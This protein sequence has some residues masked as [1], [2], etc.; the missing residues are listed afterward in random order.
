M[1]NS[2]NDIISLL[3]LQEFMLLTFV[4]EKLCA[5]ATYFIFYV[6]SFHAAWI[7]HQVPPKLLR[8]SICIRLMVALVPTIP[9]VSPPLSLIFTSTLSV[10]SYDVV[11]DCS[12]T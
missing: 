3:P 5:S 2:W 11:M 8:L 9:R 1:K 7:L 6:N 12:P 4:Q 10:L